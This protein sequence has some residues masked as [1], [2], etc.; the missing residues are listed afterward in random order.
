MNDQN[1]RIDGQNRVMTALV[2]IALFEEFNS[3]RKK[4]GKSISEVQREMMRDWIARQKENEISA[5]D[6][7]ARREE[8]SK[9]ITGLSDKIHHMDNY[10]K[11]FREQG[12]DTNEFSDAETT[13]EKMRP[14][15]EAFQVRK[16]NPNEIEF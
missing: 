16:E 15:L 14:A 9:R 2:T 13:L 4:L 1:G 7:V 6:L 3:K 5:T 10:M 12:G 8:L 11:L